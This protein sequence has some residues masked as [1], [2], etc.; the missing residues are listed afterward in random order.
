MVTVLRVVFVVPVTVKPFVH[1]IVWGYASCSRPDRIGSRS[2]R[3]DCSR[4]FLK[5][6]L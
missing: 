3:T 2:D 1:C 4:L 5:S 6:K